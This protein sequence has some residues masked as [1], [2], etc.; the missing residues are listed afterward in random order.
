[1]W[2]DNFMSI[3]LNILVI[4]FV[5]CPNCHLSG[6]FSFALRCSHF[7]SDQELKE[8]VHAWLVTQSK[9]IFILK[10]YRSL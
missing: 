5:S 2:C 3:S 4:W 9:N 7:S 6:P 8:A 1:V 10:A